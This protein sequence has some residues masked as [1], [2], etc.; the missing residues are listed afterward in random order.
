MDYAPPDTKRTLIFAAAAH[1]YKLS[2]DAYGNYVAQYILDTGVSDACESILSQLQGCFAALSRQK[3]ASNVVEKALKLT[4]V[5]MEKWR[6]T[7]VRELIAASDL[8]ELLRDQYGNY[9]LQVRCQCFK[10]ACRR[11]VLSVPSLQSM[12]TAV[13]WACWRCRS[14][15]KTK[16]VMHREKGWSCCQACLLHVAD[17]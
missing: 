17:A 9:V 15:I 13:N 2:Q 6:D 4:M 16:P 3:F 5:G 14:V 8:A 1:G 11:L 10:L 12:L 7:I